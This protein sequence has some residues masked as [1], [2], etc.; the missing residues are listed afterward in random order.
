MFEWFER[1]KEDIINFITNR[2]SI[3]T[4]L[5]FGMGI[6][7]LFRKRKQ[8][9]NQFQFQKNLQKKDRLEHQVY[10]KTKR[11]MKQIWNKREEKHG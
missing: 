7:L 10:L 3:L 1:A 11:L 9:L 2:V 8:K 6:V 4:F 5:F